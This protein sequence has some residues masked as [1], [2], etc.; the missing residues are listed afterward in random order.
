MLY[1][2]TSPYLKGNKYQNRGDSILNH[3]LRS[4]R[5]HN[6]YIFGILHA[7]LQLFGCTVEHTIKKHAC[8]RVREHSYFRNDGGT[9]LI[10]LGHIR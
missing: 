3:K 1:S 9:I 2:D 4:V 6:R 5:F 10:F 8:V 7:E